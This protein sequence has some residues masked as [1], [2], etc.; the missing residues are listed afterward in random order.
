MTK[1][2]DTNNVQIKRNRK[3]EPLVERL[4]TRK[5]TYSNK[6]IFTYIKDLMVFAAMVGYTLDVR[7]NL[8]SDAIQIVLSTYASDEKDGFIYLIA[9]L[10]E[11]DPLC[12]KDDSL[13]ASIKHFEQY[14]N[15]GLSV[16]QGWLEENPGDSEAV[17][18]LV[19]KIYTQIVQNNK[20]ETNDD[21]PDPQF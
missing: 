1:S 7:E 12:L 9:L 4:C 2:L 21:L 10:E 16:I 14:C 19:E 6:A 15:G 18:T 5:S 17:D 3:Y 8:E 20:L 11:Q 13:L